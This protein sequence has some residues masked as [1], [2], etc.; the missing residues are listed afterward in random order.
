MKANLMI[1]IPQKHLQQHPQ[2]YN[3]FGRVDDDD[4]VHCN[5][6]YIGT[7]QEMSSTGRFDEKMSLLALQ[8]LFID[9]TVETVV[10]RSTGNEAGRFVWQW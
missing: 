8:K 3:I 7:R 9:H 6:P 10:G 1:C 2:K 4:V 5:S